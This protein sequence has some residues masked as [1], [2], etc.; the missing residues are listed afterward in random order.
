MLDED[1]REALVGAERRA[2]DAVR[3]VFLPVGAG[4]DEVQ[5]RR[6]GEIQLHGGER[7][8][9]AGDGAELD[10]D[11]RAVERR[12]AGGVFVVHV[13]LGEQIGDQPLRAPPVLRRVDVLLAPLGIVRVPPRK[14]QRIVR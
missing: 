6:H 10:V 11:L 12:L 3:R 5:A 14:T 13:H 7:L 8:L 2:V 4:V 9:A 1:R